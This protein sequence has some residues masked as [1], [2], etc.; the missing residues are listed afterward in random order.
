MK[1]TCYGG[2]YTCH[3]CKYTPYKRDYPCT[4]CGKYVLAPDGEDTI[5]VY[6]N[7][8]PKEDEN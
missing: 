4:N 5:Y 1:C 8:A 7:W 2:H 3:G 6:T